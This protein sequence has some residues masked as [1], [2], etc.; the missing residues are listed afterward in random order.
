MR[1]DNSDPIRFLTYPSPSPPAPLP[2]RPM[3]VFRCACGGRSPNAKVAHDFKTEPTS[4]VSI[5]RDLHAE[6]VP[7]SHH[8]G[9]GYV[10]PISS[11]RYPAG[12]SASVSTIIG[13][14][15]TVLAQSTARENRCS[16]SGGSGSTASRS[17]P[18]DLDAGVAQMRPLGDGS[19][20]QLA[21]RQA[22]GHAE[23]FER[24]QTPA[25]RQSATP[26][27]AWRQKDCRA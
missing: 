1:E 4:Q 16:A 5:S 20:R 6:W 13:L 12:F 7:T 19:H 18:T 25:V 15:R 27:A 14:S 11:S 24:S 21:T 2:C 9:F 3:W 26:F 8:V 23:G 22:I 17:L 10:S